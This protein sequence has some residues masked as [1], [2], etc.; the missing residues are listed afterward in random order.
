[1]NKGIIFVLSGPSGAGKSTII[2]ALKKDDGKIKFSVSATTRNP[3]RG[4]KEGVD[5]FFINEIKFRKM[6][7]NHEFIEWAVFQG[8]YYGTMWRM[9]ENIINSGFDCILDIDVQGARQIKER[10]DDAVFVFIA[11]KNIN[12]LKKRLA[13]RKTECEAEIRKRLSI[14]RKEM[15]YINMYDYVV[16]NDKFEAAV[17]DIKSIIKAERCKTIRNLEI[18][19]DLKKKI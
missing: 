4:E 7:D 15:Q 9:V 3:R 5:Y 11:P 6:T 16:V 19:K 2:S 18:I 10:I 17:K 13:E 12:V 1:M 14:A 8:N